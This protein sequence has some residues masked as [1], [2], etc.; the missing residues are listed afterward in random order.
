MRIRL[1]IGACALAVAPLATV[2]CANVVECVNFG[3]S[4]GEVV[5][6]GAAI[7]S[8]ELSPADLADAE[9]QVAE[10]RSDVPDDVQDDFGVVADAFDEFI[11]QV[12]PDGDGEATEAE[13]EA[14]AT[15][16]DTPEVTAAMDEMTR[17]VEENC[18]PGS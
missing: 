2:G 18:V 14:A 16:F 10:A 12:D 6:Y 9:A 1:A 8:G 11:A 15:A 7:Q 17:W 4:A 3:I 13:I 5:V